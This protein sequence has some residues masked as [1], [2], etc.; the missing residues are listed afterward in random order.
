[1]S[2]SETTQ[3]T[4][5]PIHLKP[6]DMTR[7][8]AAWRSTTSALRRAEPYGQ[9]VVLLALR[10]LYGG[11]FIQTGWGKLTHL[12]GT[13][14]FFES[15]GLPAPFL[16]AVLV[17]ATELLGGVALALGLGTRIVAAI[18]T[19]VMMMA[20]FSAHAGEAFASF[21]AFTEQAPFPFLVASVLALVFGAGWASVD[22]LIRFL[23]RNH[24]SS[25][26]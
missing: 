25:G 9:S 18:L 12:E 26:D 21:T 22:G 6:E 14:G 16:T 8:S 15:L 7:W 4:L 3:D 5:I 23:G 1:M 11:F 19:F 24:S 20:I 10:L 17:G 2:T 13:S